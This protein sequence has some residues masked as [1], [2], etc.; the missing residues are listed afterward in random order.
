MT[1]FVPFNICCGWSGFS[2]V[3]N[4]TLLTSN[5]K[6]ATTDLVAFL[7]HFFASHQALKNTPFFVVAESY[8][9]KFASELGVALKE[10]I[11]A[12]SLNINFKGDFL[13]HC[14]FCVL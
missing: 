10:K 9:G 1:S 13:V 14:A 6:Q 8:G 12:G 11:D 3:E 2:Y 5:N 7:E 4:S